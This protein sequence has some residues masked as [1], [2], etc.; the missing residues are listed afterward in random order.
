MAADAVQEQ[1][2]GAFPGHRERE[3]RR[4]PDED[5]LQPYSALAP[6]IFTAT[7]RFSRSDLI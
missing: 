5:G 2:Q 3:A 1:H 6:E 4:R 7:P